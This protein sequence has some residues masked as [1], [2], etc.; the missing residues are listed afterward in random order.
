M[1]ALLEA[2]KALDSINKQD[3]SEIK[4]FIQPPKIVKFTLE[5]VCI[6]L[7]E[8][9]EWEHIK[10][11]VGATNF[12]DRLKKYDKDN[13]STKI[14]KRFR[15]KIR[16]NSNYTPQ[17]VATKSLASSSICKWTLAINEYAIA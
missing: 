12:I 16:N 10:K 2:I 17:K 7:Q 3:I 15:K 14:L 1:P 4:S 5:V 6:L 9:S 11:V 8:N 13:I